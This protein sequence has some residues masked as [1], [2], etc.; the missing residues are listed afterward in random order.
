MDYN[1]QSGALQSINL[2]VSFEADGQAGP[3]TAQ[4]CH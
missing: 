4:A 1:W 2:K 3:L